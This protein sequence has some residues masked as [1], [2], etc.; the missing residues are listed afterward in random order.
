M[1]SQSYPS[2]LSLTS[3]GKTKASILAESRSANLRSLVV[4]L[5][6]FASVRTAAQD[7]LSY[8]ETLDVIINNAGI[9]AVTPYTLSPDG[10]EL[11]FATNHL[12]HFLL[13]NLIRPRLSPSVRV[14]NVSSNGHTLSPIRFTDHNFSA[15]SAYN[16]WQ[17]YG[18]A[19]TAN[20]LFSVSLAERWGIEAFSLHPGE[21][22][23]NLPA[24]MTKEE[25]LAV[26][27]SAF[28]LK[29]G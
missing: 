9:M 19:K 3:I 15:G 14:V 7:V 11:Q 13:T 4:D 23:T 26:S 8:A 6:S 10:I 17:A 25:M 16:E 12:G 27:E 21:I 29:C 18:Q 5:S 24:Q 22:W 20:V 2:L 1:D 28:E